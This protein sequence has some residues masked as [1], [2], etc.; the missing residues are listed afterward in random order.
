MYLGL[1]STVGGLGSIAAAAVFMLGKSGS[2]L[3]AASLTLLAVGAAIVSG[4]L[5]A[6]VSGLP[7]ANASE[8]GMKR[9]SG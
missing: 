2:R 3:D 4:G 6:L 5:A 1:A 7:A 9:T 8:R